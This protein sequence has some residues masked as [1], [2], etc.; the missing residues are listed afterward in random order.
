MDLLPIKTIKNIDVNSDYEDEYK[1]DFE[2]GLRYFL[3][4]MEKD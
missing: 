2:L 3:K 4:K 1:K